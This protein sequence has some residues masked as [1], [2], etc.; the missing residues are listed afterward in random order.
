MS[1]IH[2]IPP[3]QATGDVLEMYRRQQNAYGYLPNYAKVYCYRPD[4]MKAWAELQAV[5]R[6][7]IDRKTFELVTLAAARAIDNSYC[8]LAHGKVLQNYYSVDELRAILTNDPCAPVSSAERAMM[9][10]AEKVARNSSAVSREEI[11]ELQALGVSDEAVFDIVAVA[12]ARCFFGKIGDA[13][14]VEPDAPYAELDNG[15]KALLVVG[16]A[17]DT[18]SPEVLAD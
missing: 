4:V 9:G 8:C 15:L 12:A 13:L 6:R 3:E 14:G 5:I 2:T 16:R 11:A 7:H 17:I 1:F 18:R 10:L